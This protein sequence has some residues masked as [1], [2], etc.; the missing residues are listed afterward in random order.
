VSAE[1]EAGTPAEPRPV[2]SARAAKVRVPPR[3]ARL[4]VDMI[5]GQNVVK[6]MAIL[7]ATNKKAAPIVRALLKSALSNA[8]QADQQIDLDALSVK[9][10][11]V[12]QGTVLK[13]F[14]PRAMGRAGRIRKRS[15]RITVRVG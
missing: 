11:F 13:R 6:A 15:S 3:K 5:R 2:Y 7:D 14:M 4:V 1:T 9:E 12:D 10:A 8:E